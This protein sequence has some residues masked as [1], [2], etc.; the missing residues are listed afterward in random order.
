MVK[1]RLSPCMSLPV[2]H[3][4]SQYQLRVTVSPAL[5]QHF[6]VGIV[7]SLSSQLRMT[8]TAGLIRPTL[9]QGMHVL[10][11]VMASDVRISSS[12]RQ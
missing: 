9:G 7:G 2:S 8:T 6:A 1:D 11:T 10:S 4:N 12:P 3:G 5:W